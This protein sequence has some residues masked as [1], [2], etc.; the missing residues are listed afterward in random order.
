MQAEIPSPAVPEEEDDTGKVTT[1]A[2]FISACARHFS[3]QHT[4]LF[5]FM[6]NSCHSSLTRVAGVYP[7]GLW[8][9]GI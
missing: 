2:V 1:L 6:Y 8:A 7:S 3:F 9:K 5:I 4:V